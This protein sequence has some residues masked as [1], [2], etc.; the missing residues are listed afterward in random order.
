MNK[1]QA[2]ALSTLA[3]LDMPDDDV[4]VTT[5]I[6]IKSKGGGETYDCDIVST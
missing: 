3:Y 2:A 1:K 4:V 5:L 6:N